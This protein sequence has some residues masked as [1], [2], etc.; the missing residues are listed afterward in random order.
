MKKNLNDKITQHRETESLSCL[1]GKRS[2][3]LKNANLFSPRGRVHF[4]KEKTSNAALFDLAFVS[5][6]QRYRPLSSFLIC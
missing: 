2:V 1:K 6:T 5:F 3:V 4:K